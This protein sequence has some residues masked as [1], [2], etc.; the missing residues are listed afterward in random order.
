MLAQ[1]RL[2]SFASTLAIFGIACAA[3]VEGDEGLGPDE[4]TVLEVVDS[5]VEPQAG[6]RGTATTGEPVIKVCV[7]KCSKWCKRMPSGNVVCGESCS[8]VFN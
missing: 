7:N 3:P 8:C 4:P 2:L 5:P 1:V 6:A